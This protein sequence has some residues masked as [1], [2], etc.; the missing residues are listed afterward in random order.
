MA[1]VAIVAIVPRYPPGVKSHCRESVAPPP[2][3]SRTLGAESYSRQNFTCYA[4]SRL[5]A[6]Q[7]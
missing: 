7:L 2:R 3:A 1:I 5:P 6:L 4:L